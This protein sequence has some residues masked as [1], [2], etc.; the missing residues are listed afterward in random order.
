MTSFFLALFGF[1]VITLRTAY[2]VSVPEDDYGYEDTNEHE[3]K[4][5][6]SSWDEETLSSPN[7]VEIAIR[8]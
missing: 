5:A 7:G 2:L 6:A 8:P 3:L 1:L 4:L